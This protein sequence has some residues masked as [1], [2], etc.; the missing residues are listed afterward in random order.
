[1]P[2]YT[3][4]MDYKGGTYISQ[5]NASSV[6]TACK[7]WAENLEVSEIANFEIKGKEILIREM[8]SKEPV[9]LEGLENVWFVSALIFN[10]LA[11]INLIKTETPNNA[12]PKSAI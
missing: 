6:K 2:L 9:A 12:N 4:I 8:K 10:N 7:E 5:V 1:M 3:F 11:A